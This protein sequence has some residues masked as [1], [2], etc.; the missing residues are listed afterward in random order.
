VLAGTPKILICTYT[1][2]VLTF[3]TYTG[4]IGYLCC[5]WLI[6]G[7]GGRAGAPPSLLRF[8]FGTTAI[9]LPS[10]N[11]CD[12]FRLHRERVADANDVAIPHVEKGRHRGLGEPFGLRD[13]PPML[14]LVDLGVPPHG[15][16]CEYAMV[17]LRRLEGRLGSV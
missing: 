6:P 11:C 5:T 8:D 12:N 15:P 2:G 14:L 10:G 3:C 17:R 13:A 9:D 1:A 7:A 4:A 16:F